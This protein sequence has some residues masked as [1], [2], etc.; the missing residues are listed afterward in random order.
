MSHDVR[1]VFATEDRVAVRFVIRGTHTG[2]FFG[3]PP[4]GRAV[5]IPANVLLHVSGGKVT[6]VLGV[7]RTIR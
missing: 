2:S 6:K 5:T 7:R 1:E 3:L 4:T